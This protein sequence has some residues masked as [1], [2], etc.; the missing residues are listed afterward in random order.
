MRAGAGDAAQLAHDIGAKIVIPCHY[1]MFEFNTADPREL[2]VPEC[3]R[4]GQPY[5]VLKLGER[6]TY[7]EKSL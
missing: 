7:P 3:E 1:D 2:F 5:R 6:F 4:L